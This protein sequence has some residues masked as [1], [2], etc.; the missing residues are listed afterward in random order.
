[1]EMHPG[2]LIF[3]MRGKGVA[4]KVVRVKTLVESLDGGVAEQ[5]ELVHRV[6]L[7]SKYMRN[8]SA[9]GLGTDT[10]SAIGIS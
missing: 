3:S 9:L 1:M 6:P 8:C 5:D 4:K 7:S 2:T 10:L